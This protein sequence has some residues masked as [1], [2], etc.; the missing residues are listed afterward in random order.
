M[1]NFA[2]IPI[3]STPVPV[4]KEI[5]LYKLISSLS[6]QCIFFAKKHVSV[7]VCARVFYYLL[8]TKH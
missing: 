8:H 3:P 2:F 7:R 5:C 4:L 1:L 6:F